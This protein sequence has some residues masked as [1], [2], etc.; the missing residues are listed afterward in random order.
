MKKRI[1]VS[2]PGGKRVDARI[3]HMIVPT[4][5]SFENGGTGTAAEPFQLFLASIATC[6]GIYVLE[7]CLAREISMEGMILSLSYDMDEKNQVCKRLNIDLTLPAGFPEEY[8][9]PVVRVM[10]ICSVKKYILN[11]PEFIITAS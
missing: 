10:D 11:A 4:D 6:V 8:K 2:F 3:G 1:E 5:Q 7:F 9:K